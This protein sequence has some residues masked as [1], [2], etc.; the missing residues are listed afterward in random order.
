MIPRPS[1]TAAAIWCE[2]E[3]PDHAQP[4]ADSSAAVTH[5]PGHSVN[6][7]HAC[8]DQRGRYVIICEECHYAGHVEAL[9][10]RES[11]DNATANHGGAG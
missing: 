7:A 10:K 4:P 11:P 8:R 6:A 3:H 9:F 1:A 5:P 2:C